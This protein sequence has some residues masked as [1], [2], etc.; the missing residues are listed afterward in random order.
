MLIALKLAKEGYGTP[1]Q[2]LAMR[3]DIVVAAVEYETF[4]NEYDRTIKVLNGWV[5]S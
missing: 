3:S 4:L 2:V 5:N 1:D